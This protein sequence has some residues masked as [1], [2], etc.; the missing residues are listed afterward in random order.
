MM[1]K[2]LLIDAANLS[3][4]ATEITKSESHDAG[5]SLMMWNRATKTKVRPDNAIPG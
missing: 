4:V 1:T 3:L 2:T 5:S